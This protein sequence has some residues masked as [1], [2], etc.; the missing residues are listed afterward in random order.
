MSEIS[1]EVD[2]INLA[3]KLTSDAVKYNLQSESIFFRVVLNGDVDSLFVEVRN[4][5]DN[6]V[7]TSFRIDLNKNNRAELKK[8]LEKTREYMS[9]IFREEAQK[10]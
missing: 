6:I 10:R 9:E 4:R 1:R 8:S 5:V 2:I 7:K 3:G